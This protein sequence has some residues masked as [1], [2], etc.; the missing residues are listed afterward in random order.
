M[1]ED[2]KTV[3]LQKE[4]Q[5]DKQQDSRNRV[6]PP[7]EALSLVHEEDRRRRRRRKRRKKMMRK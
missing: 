6:L 5:E 2:Y 3:K 1:V 7:V 4:I